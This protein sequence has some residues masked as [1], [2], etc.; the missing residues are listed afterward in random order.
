MRP[1]NEYMWHDMGCL[2]QEDSSPLRAINHAHECWHRAVA[3]CS[4]PEEARW[5]QCATLSLYTALGE[6]SRSKHSQSFV[7]GMATSQTVVHMPSFTFVSRLSSDCGTTGEL[8]TQRECM[9]HKAIYTRFIWCR[10]CMRP[11]ITL[12]VQQAKAFLQDNSTGTA[13]T[14]HV[15]HPCTLFANEYNPQGNLW[16]R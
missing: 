10:H 7:V 1:R 8:G 12:N 9:Q 14:V 4:V 2:Q 5:R 3:S 11:R 13:S 6:P 15:Q 16:N